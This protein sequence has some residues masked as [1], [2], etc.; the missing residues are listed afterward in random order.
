MISLIYLVCLGVGLLFTLLSALMGHVFGHGGG[1]HGGDHV[2]GSH[3]GV[4]A[5]ADGSD[6]PGISAFSPSIIASFITAFGGCGLLFSR[7]PALNDPL[8]SAPLAILGAFGVAGGLLLFLRRVFAHT[9]SSSEGHVGSLVGMSANAVCPI[10]ENGVGEI[11]YVQGGCR[12]TA[13]AREVNG[14]LVPTGATVKI[15]KIVGSQF[16]VTPIH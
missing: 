4:E 6:M 15:V 9:Q 5:G 12:Y 13:P 2:G 1:D 7:I 11:A 10:P 3:G 8:F 16:F 14:Q